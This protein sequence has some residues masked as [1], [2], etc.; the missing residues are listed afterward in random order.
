MTPFFL[1]QSIGD[2]DPALV[3]RAARP[4]RR[5][6]PLRWIAA[7]AAAAV[8]VGAVG[9]WWFNGRTPDTPSVAP[10]VTTTT[11]TRPDDGHGSGGD[12]KSCVVHGLEYH[13]I[14][15]SPKQVG[16]DLYYAYMAKYGYDNKDE[17][18]P[19][20]DTTYPYQDCNYP[21]NN[22]IRFVQFCGVTREQF[23]QYMG[24]DRFIAQMGEQ[25]FLDHVFVYGNPA[26]EEMGRELFTYGEYLDAIY[27]DD[28]HL[29]AW[30][31]SAWASR[32]K[33]SNATGDGDWPYQYYYTVSTYP[34]DPLARYMEKREGW[35]RTFDYHG[36]V[37]ELVQEFGVTREEFIAVYGWGDKLDE[38][39]TDHFAYAPYTYRQF[40]DAVF[41]DDEAL[42]NWVFD[43]YVFRPG[44]PTTP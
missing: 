9:A 31:F 8:A 13:S 3:E 35:G 10:P 4:L 25:A 18:F 26:E 24:W 27:G 33:H 15:I 43:C 38:K 41:G 12:E 7:V 23:I 37:I 36:S 30:V 11:T 21:E 40:V 44:Y 14:S 32:T 39:A 42:R 34:L 20:P 2:I 5:V 16:E 22:I 1:L 6:R 17:P 19:E 29:T 28:P